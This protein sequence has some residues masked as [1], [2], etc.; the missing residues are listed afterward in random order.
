MGP[1]RGPSGEYGCRCLLGPTVAS[2]VVRGH[3]HITSGHAR[4]SGRYALVGFLARIIHGWHVP[5]RSEGR[6]MA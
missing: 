4:R 1:F 6:G 2:R 3:Q 5:E